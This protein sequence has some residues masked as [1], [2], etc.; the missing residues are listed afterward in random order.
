MHA[1]KPGIWALTPL[2]ALFLIISVQDTPFPSDPAGS[3]AVIE[4]TEVSEYGKH[5]LCHIVPEHVS[6]LD[7]AGG[8]ALKGR[9][10]DPAPQLSDSHQVDVLRM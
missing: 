7:R 1:G 8:S 10:H 6:A 5:M 4:Q 3:A 9:T 2:I